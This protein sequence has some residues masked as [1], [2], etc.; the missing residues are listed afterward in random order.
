M[1]TILFAKDWNRDKL[2]LL[3]SLPSSPHAPYSSIPHHSHKERQDIQEQRVSVLAR[4][5]TSEWDHPGLRG[6]IL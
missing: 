4:T 2:S 3:F 6:Q 1:E 5:R